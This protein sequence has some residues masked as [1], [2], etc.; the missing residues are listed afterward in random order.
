MYL[1]RQCAER[2]KDSEPEEHVVTIVE[3][4]EEHKEKGCFSGIKNLF[5]RHK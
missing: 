4:K 1:T 2:I 3:R 5:K